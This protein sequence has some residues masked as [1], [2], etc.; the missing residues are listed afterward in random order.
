[1]SGVRIG[2][3]LAARRI[4]RRCRGALAVGSAREMLAVLLNRRLYAEMH[5]RISIADC[6]HILHSERAPVA[7]APPYPRKVTP[8]PPCRP[9][10]SGR[11]WRA[12]PRSA[13][14]RSQRRA[15][16]ASARPRRGAGARRP[17]R[18]ARPRTPCAP[19]AARSKKYY[20]YRSIKN[21]QA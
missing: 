3:L 17:Q 20:Y 19:A 18:A 6:R 2:S 11:T 14:A 13:L 9:A 1:L 15:P 4:A 7:S 5:A 10:A 8:A 21:I 16:R 12:P